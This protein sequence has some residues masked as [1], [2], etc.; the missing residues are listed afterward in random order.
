M[1]LLARHFYSVVDLTVNAKRRGKGQNY[2]LN[3]EKVAG[4]T[5][6]EMVVT[7]ILFG[8]TK[9]GRNVDSHVFKEN[10]NPVSKRYTS[11]LESFEKAVVAA[12]KPVW[13]IAENKITTFT[14]FNMGA[15]GFVIGFIV[16][17]IIVLFSS[18][19]AR[20]TW[21]VGT[22]I[23]L[24]LILLVIDLVGYTKWHL[25]YTPDGWH[26]AQDWL[27]FGNMLKNVGQFDLKQV[28]DVALWDRYIGYGVVLGA[29]AEVAKALETYH[30]NNHDEMFDS[31]V[32]TYIAYSWFDSSFTSTLASSDSANTSSGGGFGAGG[33][34]GGFGG[35][36]GGGAF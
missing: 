29:G 12:T 34:S 14:L 21:W 36:S 13:L 19:Y 28:P 24:A 18:D 31:Y 33:S 10:D 26:E 9:P 16:I 23:L 2:Q 4:M 27:N 7:R 17:E 30:I 1:D 35:G 3:L 5:D 15:L 25:I 32:P 11:L 8:S 22:M 6:Y 20:F